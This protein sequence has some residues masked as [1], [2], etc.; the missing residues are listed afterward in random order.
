MNRFTQLFC[1]GIFT[2]IS[3]S[4][5][6]SKALQELPMDWTSYSEDQIELYLQEQERLEQASR[7]ENLNLAKASLINGNIRRAKFFLDRIQEVEGQEGD[8]LILVKKHYQA[9]VA[10][11]ENQPRKSLSLLS[12]P[13]LE[14]PSLYPQTCL[15]KIINMANY[16]MSPEFRRELT[17]C[18]RETQNFS[19]NEQFW[20]DN[21]LILKDNDTTEIRGTILSAIEFVLSTPDI[22]RIWLKSGL[23]FN[24]EKLILDHL[25]TLTDAVYRSPEAR[26]IIALLY[27][28]Q[29]NK[30]M[31]R[32]FVED[33]DSP[34]ADNIR[35]NLSLDEKKYELAFGHYKLALQKKQNSLN[36]L[37]RSLPLAW[38]LGQWDDG[39]NLLD[40][41]I[42][43]ELD[44]RNKQALRVAFIYQS[45][46]YQEAKEE[47]NYLERLFKFKGPLEVD[48]LKNVIALQTQDREESV[49]S[50]NRACR[51]H[52]GLNCWISLQEMTWG[53]FGKKISTN[54]EVVTS[55]D[56][57]LDELRKPSSYEPIQ[58]TPI[59]DQK[60]IEEIDGG[61]VQ[62]VPGEFY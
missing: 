49:E 62:L 52:D 40:S 3:I 47:L 56:F 57:D 60:D 9:L 14:R 28:R 8:H 30:E 17:R 61:Q 59:I 43:P 7:I 22:L 41:L 13:K 6:N 12:H 31:A 18:Q 38:I 29:N 4:S 16:P 50:S 35:G 5:A 53:H 54:E 21:L 51:R 37:E 32:N 34:N 39:V 27:Y 26:E 44:P 42:K 33:I 25:E 46:D 48:Q 20:L 24:Q 23:F 10:F 36:A 45:G 15:L 58:E 1:V 2:L 19:K 55:T 11:I